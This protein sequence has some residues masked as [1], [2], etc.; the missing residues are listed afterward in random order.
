MLAKRLMRYSATG[1]L[2]CVVVASV[3][4]SIELT[5]IQAVWWVLRIAAFASVWVAAIWSW[6]YASERKWKEFIL[7]V[8]AIL[9]GVAATEHFVHQGINT[10]RLTCPH[11]DDNSDRDSP[12]E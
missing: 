2:A 5:V 8:L 12:N 4:N 11:C 6:K 9:L 3:T 1:I 7:A 10:G